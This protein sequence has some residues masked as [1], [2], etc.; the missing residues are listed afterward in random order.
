MGNPSMSE[1]NVRRMLQILFELLFTTSGPPTQAE[2]R[3]SHKRDLLKRDRCF[4]NNAADDWLATDAPRIVGAMVHGS[5]SMDKN[6]LGTLL[7]RAANFRTRAM[8]DGTWG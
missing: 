2:A 4:S 7:G 8:I 5:K 6:S 1:E 3:W